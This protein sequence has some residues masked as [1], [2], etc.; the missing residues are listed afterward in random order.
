M[1]EVAFRPVGDGGCPVHSRGELSGKQQALS[2]A[3]EGVSI[4]PRID[5]PPVE[6]PQ[7][8][9][10]RGGSSDSSAVRELFLLQ[11][12]KLRVENGE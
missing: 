4:R 10:E 3:N 5:L 12:T 6:P 9:F 7:G 2:L 1:V 8:P 11:P